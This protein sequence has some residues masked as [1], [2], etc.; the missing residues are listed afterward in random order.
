M[1]WLLI[2]LLVLLLGYLFF[3]AI[4]QPCSKC[5]GDK[6]LAS[7]SP[8][9]L[10]YPWLADIHGGLQKVMYEEPADSGKWRDY[11][12]KVWA[13][14]CEVINHTPEKLVA[15]HMRAFVDPKTRF[16]KLHFYFKDGTVMEPT[17][18]FYE[19]EAA[20]LAKN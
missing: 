10:N 16:A 4:N 5:N 7:H 14:H 19:R 13:V 1:M 17:Q 18:E 12:D 11:D 15:D 9:G 20:W 6:C 3:R 2:L 8:N